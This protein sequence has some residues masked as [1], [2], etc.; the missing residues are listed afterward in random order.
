MVRAILYILLLI[1]IAQVLELI[2]FPFAYINVHSSVYVLLAIKVGSYQNDIVK[3]SVEILGVNFMPLKST[4]KLLSFV[5][6]YLI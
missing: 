5:L 3:L 4:Y 1:D 2:S 6:F